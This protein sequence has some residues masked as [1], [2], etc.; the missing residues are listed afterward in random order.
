M[1]TNKT[2]PTPK[3][4][5]EN[6]CDQSGTG[7]AETVDRDKEDRRTS[8]ILTLDLTTGQESEALDRMYRKN[9]IGR[10]ERCNSFGGG[11]RKA[12]A[13]LSKEGGGK[14][15]A[16]EDSPYKTVDCIEALT[17]IEAIKENKKIMEKLDKIDI[18]DV[19]RMEVTLERLRRNAEVFQRE[20]I[21]QWLDRNSEE[22]TEKMLLD[23]ESQTEGKGVDAGVQT[24]P[25]VGLKE[26]TTAEGIN[27]WEKLEELKDIEW[28]GS[29]YARTEIKIGNPALG[30]ETCKILVKERSRDSGAQ[31]AYVRRYPELG[32]L[33]GD[34]EV[35][36]SSTKIRSSNSSRKDTRIFSLKPMGPVDLWEKLKQVEAEVQDGEDV[37]IHHV[38]MMDLSLFR[39][40]LECIFKNGTGRVTLYTS[41]RKQN[42][43]AAPRSYGIVVSEG[44]KPYRE[45][46]DIVKKTITDAKDIDAVRGARSTKDGKVLLLLDRNVEAMT[47]IK[48]VLKDSGRV[49]A[50]EVGAGKTIYHM[51]G[52]AEGTSGNEVVEA[53]TSQCGFRRETITISQLRPNRGGTLAATVSIPAGMEDRMPEGS[54]IRVGL[55]RCRVEKRLEVRKCFKCW[56]YDHEARECTGEDRSGACYKCGIKG[57]KAEE[58]QNKER[59]PICDEEGHYLGSGRCSS[60]R[61]ALKKARLKDKARTI[62]EGRKTSECT[63]EI[64][65]R[66]SESDSESNGILGRLLRGGSVER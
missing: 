9:I 13:G 65:R 54:N 16:K 48:R 23:M 52:M 29:A 61:N 63:E 11:K 5:K 14:R 62:S 56:A 39:K 53:I 12:K 32:E 49:K 25:W 21:Q 6:M 27:T 22:K 20:M 50:R 8:N 41:L 19:D 35:L 33:E 10:V 7:N 24:D 64:Q 66:E 46:L 47:N 40:V 51:R 59:C 44:N 31:D 57:H 15:P 3:Q 60:F 55:A 28:S 17:L 43:G 30:Q 1:D 58:C 42:E 2:I 34:F 4:N 18:K 26:I 38:N 36:E 45:V 37:G